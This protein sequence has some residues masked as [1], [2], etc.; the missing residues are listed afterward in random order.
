MLGGVE[1]ESRKKDV[2]AKNR[3]EGKDKIG[4]KDKEVVGW[5]FWLGFGFGL[6]LIALFLRTNE[7]GLYVLP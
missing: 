5:G 3:K 4:R 1:N 7:V 2:I 6:I